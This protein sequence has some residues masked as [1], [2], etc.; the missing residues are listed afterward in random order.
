MLRLFDR[1]HG[2]GS[3]GSQSRCRHLFRYNLASLSARRRLRYMQS[4]SSQLIHFHHYHPPETH[5]PLKRLRNAVQAVAERTFHLG[6]SPRDIKE[7]TWRLS[8]VNIAV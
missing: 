1:R 3:L 4:P 2:A 8:Y 7:L 5:T 6:S